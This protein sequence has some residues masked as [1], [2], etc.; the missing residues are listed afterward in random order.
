M[1][2]K[3]LNQQAIL[4]KR[5]NKLNIERDVAKGCPCI[6]ACECMLLPSTKSSSNVKNMMALMTLG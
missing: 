6:T 2:Q 5:R 3:K 4:G 1:K